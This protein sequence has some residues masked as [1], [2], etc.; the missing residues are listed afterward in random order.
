MSLFIQ[1]PPVVWKHKFNLA[2]QTQYKSHCLTETTL[3]INIINM[4]IYK[5]LVK[6][7]NKQSSGF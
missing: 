7:I 2:L 6:K 4:A 5:G 3:N 1:L